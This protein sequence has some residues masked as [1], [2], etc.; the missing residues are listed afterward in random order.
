M[1]PTGTRINHASRRKW[2]LEC[3]RT[4]TVGV[5]LSPRLSSEGIHF[6]GSEFSIIFYLNYTV[7]SEQKIA[8]DH[9]L[10]SQEKSTSVQQYQASK[11][12]YN[13]QATGARRP[14]NLSIF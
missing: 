6:T 11:A 8:K 5:V 9:D 12:D 3:D 1:R 4:V 7:Q 13:Q 10:I 2:T 14:I